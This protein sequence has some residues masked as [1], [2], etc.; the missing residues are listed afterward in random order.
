M[1][2]GLRK[3]AGS[4][5]DFGK[6]LQVGALNRPA[7]AG[8]GAET[9]C[10]P[11]KQPK[12]SWPTRFPVPPMCMR[13][14]CLRCSRCEGREKIPQQNRQMTCHPT[15]PIP[16]A[17]SPSRRRC[18]RGRRFSRF[19]W[20]ALPKSPPSCHCAP[21][22]ALWLMPL[23]LRR[24]V[25]PCSGKIE[26]CCQLCASYITHMQKVLA[27]QAAQACGSAL[28]STHGLWF[29]SCCASTWPRHLALQAPLRRNGSIRTRLPLV[30]AYLAVWRAGGSELVLC[31]YPL[32]RMLGFSG[33]DKAFPCGWCWRS[34][35][36]KP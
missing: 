26:A 1:A 5:N 34:P 8:P 20:F 25:S 11:D 19:L 9:F 24:H 30:V 4:G 15:T 36:F 13:S 7:G 3:L 27:W 23:I 16:R 29:P 35:Q 17:L 22:A 32:L 18:R 21:Q 12:Q 10:L 14:T 6:F 2:F 28:P 31:R 33:S